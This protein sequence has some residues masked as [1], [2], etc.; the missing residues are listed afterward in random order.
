M[1]VGLPSGGGGGGAPVP[2]GTSGGVQRPATSPSPP[3]SGQDGRSGPPPALGA[4]AGA[5]VTGVG[6]CQPPCPLL[7]PPPR[8][9]GC[10]GSA[11]AAVGMVTCRGLEVWVPS[12]ETCRVPQWG[13]T[14]W[15]WGSGRRP[16][17]LGGAAAGLP[18]TQQGLCSALAHPAPRPGQ[19]EGPGR[20][21]RSSP[22]PPA[23]SEPRGGGGGSAVSRSGPSERGARG[24]APSRRRFPRRPPGARAEP[25]CCAEAA[26][27]GRLCGAVGR[28]GPARVRSP[29]GQGTWGGRR[30]A[31]ALRIFL[32]PPPRCLEFGAERDCSRGRGGAPGGRNAA[33]SL[34]RL[35]L[36]PREPG[37]WSRRGAPCCLS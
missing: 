9:E 2:P 11:P 24:P 7:E 20:W 27:E 31:G 15:G 25:Q 1:G 6:G 18:W 19:L 17:A 4:S 8:R 30:A 26:A 14:G 29:A 37:L 33:V 16:P 3:R 23:P 12:P 32:Q 10:L 34:R 5:G 13:I 35:P 22:A 21:G 36:P 28:A